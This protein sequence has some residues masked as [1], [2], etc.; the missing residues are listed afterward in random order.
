[1]NKKESKRLHDMSFQNSEA[2]KGNEDCGCFHC[3][4]SFK[5]S[6]IKEWVDK[7]RSGPD[8]ALCPRCGIDSVLPN[9]TSPELLEKM[10]VAWF[11]Y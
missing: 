5:S 4:E 3:E 8:T 1:M 2:L 9:V 7:K 10:Y 11:N 6:E